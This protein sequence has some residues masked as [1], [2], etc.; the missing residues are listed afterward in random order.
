MRRHSVD[1]DGAAVVVRAIVVV[2]RQ[3][4]AQKGRRGA[5]PR[6]LLPLG[7]A[8]L[9]HRDAAL[10]PRALHLVPPRLGARVVGDRVRLPVVAVVP[11]RRPRS[12]RHRPSLGDDARH[13]LQSSILLLGRDEPRAEA[14]GVR[15]F[16]APGRPRDVR[17]LPQRA[18]QIV[19]G[20]AREEGQRDSPRS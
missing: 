3:R 7:R 6:R 8:V 16:D 2:G 13:L 5:E 1:R 15:R 4:A 10:T 14:V 17:A 12:L 18:S 9:V 19:R 20:D 11:R